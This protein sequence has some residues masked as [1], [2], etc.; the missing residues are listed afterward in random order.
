MERCAHFSTEDVE[1]SDECLDNPGAVIVITRKHTSLW[2]SR[3][4]GH[5]RI[6]D[7]RLEG[8]LRSITAQGPSGRPLF[9][10]SPVTFRTRF[11]Q[12]LGALL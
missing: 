6:L 11:A 9:G 5:V 7:T 1:L 2:I 12:I 8:L 3:H 10:L 4:A